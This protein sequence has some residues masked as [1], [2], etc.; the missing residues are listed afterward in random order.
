MSKRWLKKFG[1]S[2]L[3]F[4]LVVSLVTVAMP[5]HVNA[6]AEAVEIGI[7]VQKA[8]DVDVVLALD[9]ST[10][11]IDSYK[12]DLERALEA[13]GV[14][15]SNLNIQAVQVNETNILEGKFKL[16]LKWER[17]A[18]GRIDMDSHVEFWND[19]ELVDE[20]SYEKKI[21]YESTLDYDDTSGGTGEIIALS[22][23][24]IPPD[25]TELKV[26]INPYN[27]VAETTMYL[28][29]IVKDNEQQLI[30]H[31]GFVE[32]KFYFGSFKRNDDSWDFHFNNGTIFAGKEVEI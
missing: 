29:K 22:L 8:Y 3:S 4:T 14:N 19:I 24:T 5:V 18:S 28:Y 17:P 11:N 25:I 16:N 23:N 12:E 10:Q 31:T 27:G 20:L 21:V 7:N 32:E 6:E 30:S 15:A 1:N 13:R 9:N 26:Y 2:I